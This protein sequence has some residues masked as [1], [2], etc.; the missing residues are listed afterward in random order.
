MPSDRAVA[1][2]A[3]DVEWPLGEGFLCSLS[4]SSDEAGLPAGSIDH[5][6]SVLIIT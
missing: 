6:L 2:R 3:E 1:T 5:G 4:E